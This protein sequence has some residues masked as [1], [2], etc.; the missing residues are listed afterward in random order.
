VLGAGVE[1][2]EGCPLAGAAGCCSQLA[3]RRLKK[4][5]ATTKHLIMPRDIDAR[6]WGIFKPRL[7]GTTCRADCTVKG[8]EPSRL[9]FSAIDRFG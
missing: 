7:K 1:E 6:G 3:R 8:I 2:L 5:R 9:F 4:A